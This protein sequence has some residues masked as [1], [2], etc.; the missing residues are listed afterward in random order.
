MQYDSPSDAHAIDFA[1]WLEA[2]TRG[3]DFVAVKMD[4]E[5]AEYDVLE[6]LLET[7]AI[8][9]IDRGA[10]DRHRSAEHHLAR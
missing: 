10:T 9:R 8:D 2:H 1:R 6:H 5:G 3:A 4:I 7:Q